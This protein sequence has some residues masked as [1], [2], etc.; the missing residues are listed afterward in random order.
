MNTAD[1][2]DWL[3]GL[4][5]R[6]VGAMEAEGG[7]PFISDGWT[8][9]PGGKLEGDGLSRLVEDAELLERGGCS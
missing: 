3:L 7:A 4:Q 6:I 8:R 9:E 5:G 1:V 2:R